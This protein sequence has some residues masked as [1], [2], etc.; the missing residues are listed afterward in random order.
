M[1]NSY[2]GHLKIYY[3]DNGIDLVGYERLEK[4]G[5]AVLEYC[6]Y[7]L[8]AGTMPSKH[9]WAIPFVKGAFCSNK[10][11]AC[12]NRKFNLWDFCS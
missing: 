5:D 2:S 4:L 3:G 6:V 7:T 1:H 9:M 12:I 10:Y 8:L 11:L